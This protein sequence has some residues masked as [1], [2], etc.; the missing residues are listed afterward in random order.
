METG[1]FSL[2]NIRCVRMAAGTIGKDEIASLAGLTFARALALGR[3]RKGTYAADRQSV[4]TLLA[5]VEGGKQS[6]EADLGTLWSTLPSAGGVSS[7]GG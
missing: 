6:E 7:T 1:S 5:A 3:D 4:E 2:W